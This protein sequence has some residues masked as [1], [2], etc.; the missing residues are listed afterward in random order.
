MRNLRS[1]NLNLLP[2]LRELLRKRNVTHA[3]SALNLS[4]SAVSDALGRLRSLL[5]DEILIADG[6]RLRPTSFAQRIERTLES[7]LS[8]I[9]G[10]FGGVPLD[11]ATKEGVIKIATVD[12]VIHLLAAPLLRRLAR[13]A[14]R[15]TVQFLDITANSAKELSWGVIDFLVAPTESLPG[16][17]ERVTLFEDD[18]V[19]L[20]AEDSGYGEKLSDEEFR[21]ARHAVYDA[22]GALAPSVHSNSLRQAG[23]WEF[24]A[25]ILPSLLLLPKVVGEANTVA[26]VPQRLA[27]ELIG[28]ANVRIVEVTCDLPPFRI[29]AFWHASKAT[30]PLHR[31][32]ME[33]LTEVAA[34]TCLLRPL[35]LQRMNDL[36][37]PAPPRPMR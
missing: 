32:F 18:A 29:G 20:V 12:Y 13:E 28:S 1:V 17:Y 37:L 16:G 11:V 2:I 27:Q 14:P 33:V 9:E 25:V 30:D 22:G 15:L 4:Q 26:I 5:G 19:C 6:R 36:A 34:E 35:H 8:Q 21:S 23:R 31:W 7:S 3:A 24:N 10:L